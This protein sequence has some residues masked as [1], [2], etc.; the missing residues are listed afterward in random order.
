MNI[1]FSNSGSKL[2]SNFY[3]PGWSTIFISRGKFML[4]EIM[5]PSL[6]DCTIL[7]IHSLIIHLPILH[8]MTILLSNLHWKKLFKEFVELI[9]QPTIPAS[10]EPSLEDT[11]EAFW[12]TVNQPFQEI[13]YANCG[14]H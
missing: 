11:L 3:T 12:Q 14:K 10:Q 8:H 6:M 13:T 7:N 2:N 4:W 9:G 1:N 5:L